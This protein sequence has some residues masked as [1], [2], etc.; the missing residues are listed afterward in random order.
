MRKIVMM[1]MMVM[2][3]SVPFAAHAK[4]V[5]SMD[6]IYHAQ[7]TI[8]K[9]W[10]LRNGVVYVDGTPTVIDG[11]PLDGVTV[12]RLGE[13]HYEVKFDEYGFVFELDF[14]NKESTFTFKP[15]VKTE[16]DCY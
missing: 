8:Q 11:E 5:K 13:D 7:N 1:F 12:T 6:C 3:V 15:V 14:Y 10:E 4:D 9:H 2:F 16:G